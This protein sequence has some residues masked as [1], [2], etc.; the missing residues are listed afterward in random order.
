MASAGGG[1]EANDERRKFV[2]PFP[3]RSLRKYSIRSAEPSGWASQAP[4]LPQMSATLAKAVFQACKALTE[5]LS[6]FSSKGG[7]SRRTAAV[8]REPACGK[9]PRFSRPL[10]CGFSLHPASDVFHFPTPASPAA[11]TITNNIAFPQRPA[12]GSGSLPGRM[13]PASTVTPPIVPLHM[14]QG[15]R[16]SPPLR[17][18]QSFQS[19]RD[20]ATHGSPLLCIAGFGVCK[21]TCVSFHSRTSTRRTLRRAFAMRTVGWSRTRKGVCTQ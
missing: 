15:K 8:R 4:Y 14:H 16:L 6:C 11:T 10:F 2:K 12:H 9:R 13:S 21:P 17:G 7:A 20:T 3:A 5:C 19:V 1:T 18:F